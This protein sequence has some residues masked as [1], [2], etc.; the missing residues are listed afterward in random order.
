MRDDEDDR[1]SGDDNDKDMPNEDEGNPF[2][3]AEENL[4]DEYWKN[5]P[6]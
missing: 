6:S 4:E 1:S 3:W 2:S 5:D